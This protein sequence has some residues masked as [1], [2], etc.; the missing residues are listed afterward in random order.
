MTAFALVIFNL[1]PCALMI[2]N[3]ITFGLIMLVLTTSLL[4]TTFTT[5]FIV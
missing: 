4:A 2:F 3:F 1:T 5:V